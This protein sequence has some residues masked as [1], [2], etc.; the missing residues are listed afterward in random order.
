MN[1]SDY[2]NSA[3]STSILPV[4]KGGT[5]QNNLADIMGVGSANK[6][7]T[8]RTING[9]SFDGSSNIAVSGQVTPLTVNT[10]SGY[11]FMYFKVL[12]DSSGGDETV[13]LPNTIIV[14]GVADGSNPF[15]FIVSM[16]EARAPEEKTLYSCNTGDGALSPVNRVRMRRG[17]QYDFYFKVKNFS[18]TSRIFYYQTNSQKVKMTQITDTAT[19]DAESASSY[20]LFSLAPCTS[21]SPEPTS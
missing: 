15:N 1:F 3:S 18:G 11:D 21:P 10:I 13:L 4:S 5:G 7:A 2:S 17:G 16:K 9:V 6:L 19:L 8:A 14:N 12:V 20:F